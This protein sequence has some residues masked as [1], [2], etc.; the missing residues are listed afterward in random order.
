MCGDSSLAV[1]SRMYR[2]PAIDALDPLLAL[3][4]AVPALD[5][6]VLGVD[7]PALPEV[8][9]PA[10]LGDDEPVVALARMNSLPLALALAPALPLVP[11]APAVAPPRCRQPVSVTVRA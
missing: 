4:P 8:D 7:A 11:V 9:D 6:L 10:L 3:E 2:D 1:P 5:P